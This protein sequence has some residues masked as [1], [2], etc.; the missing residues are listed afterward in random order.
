MKRGSSHGGSCKKL[1]KHAQRANKH[2]AFDIRVKRSCGKDLERLCGKG[3]D[4]AANEAAAETP[5][6]EDPL[7]C[8]TREEAEI[9]ED[10]CRA[11]V[12]KSVRRA[13]TFYRVGA[14]ATAACDDAATRLCGAGEDVAA[15]QAPGSVLSCLRRNVDEAG[16]ACWRAVSAD[17]PD[18]KHDV[19]EVGAIA[20]AKDTNLAVVA[21][22][23]AEALFTTAMGL[24][25]A[26]PSVA[27]YNK[28]STD[29]SRY[30]QRLEGFAAE[31]SAILSR[32]LEESK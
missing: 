17:L 25:V 24:I 3:D 19:A 4:A 7:I 1:S 27:A 29:M 28:F 23:L 26:I 22:G 12:R 14:P 11:A 30:S 2:M 32:Q 6:V 31:F 20:V 15:F 13:F 5:G 10:D 8:L 9:E 18:S 21:P 16:D